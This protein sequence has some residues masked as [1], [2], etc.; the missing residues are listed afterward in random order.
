MKQQ[1]NI[2]LGFNEAFC[3]SPEPHHG[4]PVP[5]PAPTSQLP[6]RGAQEGQPGAGVH[7][8]AVQQRGGPGDLREPAG[9]GEN[10]KVCRASQSAGRSRT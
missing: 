7:R 2:Q 10:L 6:V 8:G 4:L 5:E 9:D 1:Q 3:P